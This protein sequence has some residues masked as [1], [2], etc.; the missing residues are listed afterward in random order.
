MLNEKVNYWSY[1]QLQQIKYQLHP[2]Y[3][4]SVNMVFVIVVL[5][6][7]ILIMIGFYKK[8][9]WSFWI[10]DYLHTAQIIYQAI[11]NVLHGYNLKRNLENK[12][13]SISFDNASN[14]IKSIDYFTRVLNPIMDSR[15][16]HQKCVYHIGTKSLSLQFSPIIV[17]LHSRRSIP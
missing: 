9:I 16:F 1:L 17:I 15:I 13:F 5:P 3:G 4:P 14:N 8:K 12:I 2:I 6:P 7:I 10:M 11:I